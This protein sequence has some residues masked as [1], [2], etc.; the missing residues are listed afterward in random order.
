MVPF[1]ATA[2]QQVVNIAA[3]CGLAA[4]AF[5]VDVDGGGD[6]Y[7]IVKSRDLSDNKLSCLV[8]RE[9]REPYPIVIF[10][11][12]QL[13]RRY[14]KIQN[15]VGREESRRWLQRRGMLSSLPEFDPSSENLD[16]FARRMENYCGFQAGVVLRA[17][18]PNL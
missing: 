3:E 14:V 9:R 10:E 12:E 1:D 4:D 6:I 5:K 15:N 7:L 8:T 11:R 2:Q 18:S 13:T 16:Q 17:I